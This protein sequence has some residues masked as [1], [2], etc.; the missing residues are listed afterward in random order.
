MKGWN[1]FKLCKYNTR[2]IY[3]PVVYT[4]PPCQQLVDYLINSW[5][6]F[7]YLGHLFWRLAGAFWRPGVWFWCPGAPFCW[8]GGPQ[9]HPTGHLGGQTW[10]L[11]DFWWI[12]GPPWDQLWIHV[13]DFFVIWTT[14]W[15]HG[16]HSCFFVDLGADMAP[17]CDAW[18][19]SK[20][21]KYNGFR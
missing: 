4:P 20:H 7:G 3:Y 5:L 14:Q 16:F 21:S 11:V 2:I 13:G 18:M 12:L 8:S 6:H 19:S 15:Q 17:E 1:Y 10:M 9:G